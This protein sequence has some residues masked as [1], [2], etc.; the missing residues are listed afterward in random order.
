MGTHIVLIG[1]SIFDNGIY[2]KEG[3]DVIHQLRKLVPTGCEVTLLAKDGSVLE[4]IYLQINELPF[5]TTHIIMSAGGND[6]LELQNKFLFNKCAD[7]ESAIN[8]L[9]DIKES[10]NRIYLNIIHAIGKKNI[11][12]TLCTIYEP[13]LYDPR[14]GRI[15]LTALSLLN[16]TIVKI[17]NKNKIPYIDLRTICTEN[18]HFANPIEPSYEGSKTIA[19]AIVEFLGLC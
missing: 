6:G 9:A 4:D 16:D 19:K 13:P 17:A 8:L 15:F 1:D 14:T 7:M 3:E 2:V 18:F 12:F 10:F 5:S 11:P